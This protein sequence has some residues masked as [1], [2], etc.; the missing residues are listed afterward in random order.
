VRFTA[1]G[2]PDSAPYATHTITITPHF[3]GNHTT[4]FARAT[5]L[6]G[7]TTVPDGYTRHHHQD[8]TI[9]QL[10]PVDLHEAIRH[11]GGVG[12]TKGRPQP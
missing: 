10:V 1:D 12:I 8:T 9:M 3:A 7:L 6:A 2:F 5:R 4:D 11:A